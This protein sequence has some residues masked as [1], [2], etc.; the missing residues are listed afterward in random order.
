MSLRD[1]LAVLGTCL[2]KLGAFLRSSST[3]PWVSLPQID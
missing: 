3:E 1:L 2:S